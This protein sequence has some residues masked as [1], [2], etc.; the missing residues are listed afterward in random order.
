MRVVLNVAEKPAAAQEIATILA[1]R[2]PNKSPGFS[3]YNCIWSFKYNLNGQECDMVFT[4]VLGHLMS[5]DIQPPNDKWDSCEPIDLFDVPIHKFVNDTNQ[6]IVQTIQKEARKADTLILWLD[7]DREGENIAFEVLQKCIEVKRSLK[8]FRARF[9]AL[10]PREINNACKTL[11]APSENDAKA[12]DARIEID[13]RI[14][15]A[16]TRFQTKYIKSKFKIDPQNDGGGGSKNPISYGACQ[17]PTLGFVVER[18]FR[19]V[20]FRQEKFWEISVEHEKYDTIEKKNLIANFS[21][22]RKRLFDHNAAFILYEKCFDN[23]LAKV[24]DVSLKEK[25]YRPEPLKTIDM[26]KLASQKLRLSSEETMKYAEELYNKGIISYPRT[27]TDSF[28]EGTDFESLIKIQTQSRDWGEYAQS[29]LNGKFKTPRHGK[30]TDNSHP[31]IHPTGFPKDGDLKDNRIKSLFELITRHFLACCS[32][33]SVF[34]NTIVTIDIEEEQFTDKGVM[35]I[36]KGYLE[37][38]PYDKKKDRQIPKY[39]V[40]E[41]FNPTK[42]ELREGNTEPPHYITESEL[43]SAMD[44]DGI[45][46]DATMAQH[47]QKIQER[48]YVEK[49]QDKFKPT[50]LGISLVCGYDLMGFELSKP[51]LR[52]MIEADVQKIS[53]GK[54]S[55]E[56][57]LQT[58]IQKYK[59]IFIEASKQLDKFDQSFSQFYAPLGQEYN[60]ENEQFSRCGKCQGWMDLRNNGQ[61]K[62]ILFCTRCNISHQMPKNGI[63]EP[64]GEKICPICQFQVIQVQT[65]KNTTY[66][67]CPYCRN[68]PPSQMFPNEKLSKPL[69]CFLCPN[70]K[71]SLYNKS[72]QQLINNTSNRSNYN[73]NNNNNN[74]SKSNV[75]TFTASKSTTITNQRSTR[76]NYRNDQMDF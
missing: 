50:H 30:S 67:F 37:V 53:Q 61:D 1:G 10:I 63:M 41:T 74:R 3:K 27:E 59:E 15:A 13:L 45:G 47:I 34:G 16:F 65:E 58:T 48:F 7:C 55:K 32:H 64:L 62:R 73:N 35:L 46:T 66:N 8:V 6:P 2:T 70:D 54:I 24:V 38:Y 52:A 23:P 56:Q 57:V 20:N 49:I 40:G 5:T 18:Y 44:R 19:I 22:K 26:Q 12:I 43:L 25:R 31:P 42:L 69:H 75:K 39:E 72:R 28:Q 4:S 60:I 36:D 68:N 9:S 11:I 51:Y 33:E 21:W 29:L 17:F 71:C 14:G 76:N